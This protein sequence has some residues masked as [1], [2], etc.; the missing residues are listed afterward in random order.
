LAST[1]RPPMLI[2]S[3]ITLCTFFSITSLGI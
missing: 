1:S 3:I 2:A